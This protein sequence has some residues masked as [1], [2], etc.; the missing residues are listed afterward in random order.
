MMNYRRYQRWPQTLIPILICE[1]GDLEL[2]AFLSEKSLQ[3]SAIQPNDIEQIVLLITDCF[4]SDAVSRLFFES[5]AEYKLQMPVAVSSSIND[6][7]ERGVLATTRDYSATVCI[8]PFGEDDV[9]ISDK[10]EA[11]SNSNWSSDL[12]AW[13]TENLRMLKSGWYLEYV[14]VRHNFRGSG[15]GSQIL[16]AIMTHCLNVPLATYLEVSSTRSFNFFESLGF[17]RMSSLRLPRDT[18]NIAMVRISP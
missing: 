8:T 10:V 5:D 2:F 18:E 12:A 11:H 4:S 16:G 15:L 13:R 6:A 7:S 1:Y 17:K 14:C 9:D 3:T